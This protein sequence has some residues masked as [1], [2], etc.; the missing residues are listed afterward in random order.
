M[1]SE[2]STWNAQLLAS[3]E[4]LVFPCVSWLS[5]GGHAEQED[6][7]SPAQAQDGGTEEH[8]LEEGGGWRTG[9]LVIRVAGDEQDPPGPLEFLEALIALD[10][11]EDEVK[12]EACQEDGQEKQG[13]LLHPH[14][15]ARTLAANL[16]G[17]NPATLR[18]RARDSR[19]CWTSFIL[20]PRSQ[21][22]LLLP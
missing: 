16:Q 5:A 12:D 22:T 7:C 3:F 19:G 8:H 10:P 1:G 20:N 13:Q 2:D 4:E 15:Q 21:N 18:L 14:S 6:L 17:H 9:Y 11:G